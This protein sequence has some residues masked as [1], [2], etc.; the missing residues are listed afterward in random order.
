MEQRLSV[1]THF[2]ATLASTRIQPAARRASPAL[3]VTTLRVMSEGDFPASSTMPLGSMRTSFSSI[4]LR[5]DQIRMA[6]MTARIMARSKTRMS[7]VQRMGKLL[8]PGKLPQGKPAQKF[9]DQ[10]G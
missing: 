4:G 7:L 1:L 9:D 8:L 6:S 2:L 10:H 5:E 3:W